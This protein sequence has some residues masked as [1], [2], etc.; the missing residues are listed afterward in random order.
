M[1]IVFLEKLLRW[2][3]FRDSPGKPTDLC[4]ELFVKAT[5]CTQ[6]GT[7][8]HSCLQAT[9]VRKASIQAMASLAFASAIGSGNMLYKVWTP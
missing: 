6:F 7:T 9:H 8:W 4:T 5:L 3:Q 2:W 1:G